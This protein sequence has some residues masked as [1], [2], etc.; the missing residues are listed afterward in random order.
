MSRDLSRMEKKILE[1][2]RLRKTF[3]DTIFDKY[4][5]YRTVTPW[6][7]GKINIC[8]IFPYS[9]PRSGFNSNFEKYYSSNEALL[10][11]SSA[12]RTKFI[13]N[14]I[15]LLFDDELFVYDRHFCGKTD[16]IPPYGN[17]FRYEK[18]SAYMGGH[19]FFSSGN[20]AYAKN[21]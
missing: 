12:E 7:R 16:P 19:K 1:Y 20:F 13:S 17:I 2:T 4:A 10:S 18:E 6:L 15:C 14:L 21:M 5:T 9:L 8:I 3:L 11:F